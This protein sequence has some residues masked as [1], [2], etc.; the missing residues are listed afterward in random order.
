MALSGS[1]TGRPADAVVVVQS[2]SGDSWNDLATATLA[3]AGWAA[4]LVAPAPGSVIYRAVMRQGAAELAVSGEKTVTVVAPLT[5][6]GRPGTPT[7]SELGDQRVGLAW[8]AASAGGAPTT[9]YTVTAAPGGATC[10]TTGLSCV[11]IGLANG[12]PY[13]FT[14]LATNSFGNGPSSTPSSAFTPRTVPAAPA[15]PLAV[16]GIGGKAT[17]YWSVPIS[18]GGAADLR[19]HGGGEPG[20]LRHARPP[21]SAAPSRG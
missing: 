8:T 11:V 15:Q 13:T 10:T 5:V 12:T 18:T 4:S 20:R 6:P 21:C 1:T 2:K 14:V 16:A 19:L 7:L 9:G 17:V 3:G